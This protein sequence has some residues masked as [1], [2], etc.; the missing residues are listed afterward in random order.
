MQWDIV[1]PSLVEDEAMMHLRYQAYLKFYKI[2]IVVEDGGKASRREGMRE[3]QERRGANEDELIMKGVEKCPL[4]LFRICR[5]DVPMQ[6]LTNMQTP[7]SAPV[8]MGRLVRRCRVIDPRERLK[9]R[10]CNS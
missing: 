9:C 1:L 6:M 8:C 4:S 2:I 7:A 10:G 5:A 3:K